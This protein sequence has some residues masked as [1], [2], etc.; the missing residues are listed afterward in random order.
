MGEEQF[1]KVKQAAMAAGEAVKE[2][3][4]K[5]GLRSEGANKPA[6]ATEEE[7]RTHASPTSRHS[8]R[9]EPTKQ[10]MPS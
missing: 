8:V 9:E 10:G 4:G 3:T 5:E 7:Q 2:Q 1:E 6:R